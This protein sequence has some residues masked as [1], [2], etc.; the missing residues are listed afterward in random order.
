MNINEYNF[1]RVNVLRET[2]HNGSMMFILMP[3][4]SYQITK[5]HITQFTKLKSS[6]MYPLLVVK[7]DLTEAARIKLHK[8]RPPYH[9]S[10][11]TMI[12]P[13]CSM[14]VI[15]ATGM[16]LNFAVLHYASV[17]YLRNMLLILI[18]MSTKIQWNL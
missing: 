8:P 3:W 9:S 7:D 12:I 16:G 2:R 10:C 6:M 13:P 15:N 1:T 14:T 4:V 11:G 18:K 17:I 5:V